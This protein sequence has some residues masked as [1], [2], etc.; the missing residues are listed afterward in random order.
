[1]E[2]VLWFEQLIIKAWDARHQQRLVR[3]KKARDQLRSLEERKR[4]LVDMRLAGEID[5]E[6]F[7][8]IKADLEGRVAD[9]SAINTQPDE[10]LDL[11][12][13]LRAARR[14]IS[15]PATMWGEVLDVTE[16]QRL[17]RLVLPQGVIF[18]IG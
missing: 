4:R 3:S 12:S 16:K 9:A 14:F 5:R 1:P 13:A 17:Q 6:E 2:S 7:T 10:N 18:D 11:P 8:K 15:S